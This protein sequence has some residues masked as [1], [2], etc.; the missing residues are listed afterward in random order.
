M[1]LGTSQLRDKVEMLAK[2]ALTKNTSEALKSALTEWIKNKQDGE[3]SKAATSKMLPLLNA[4]KDENEA[5]KEI[6]SKRDHL[7]KKSQWIFGGDGWAYDIGFGGVDH[8]LASGEDVNVFVFDTEV[9]S[10]T[11]GQAS[12]STPTSAVAKFAATG[13][14]TKKKDLGM[15]A[16]TYGYVYCHKTTNFIFCDITKVIRGLKYPSGMCIKSPPEI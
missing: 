15:M 9:Y 8:V 3:G 1:F 13:K 16:M 10:N 7:V 2:K 14:R 6:F 4:E 5:L 11:G 12:K